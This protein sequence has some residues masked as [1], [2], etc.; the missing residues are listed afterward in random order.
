[1]CA[2]GYGYGLNV[3]ISFYVFIVSV[4][5]ERTSENI[6][7]MNSKMRT[8]RSNMDKM[9]IPNTSAH[10]LHGH[11]HLLLSSLL[12]L[13][14]LLRE[15]VHLYSYCALF[16]LLLFII[17][18]TGDFYLQLF[19]LQLLHL[20]SVCSRVCNAHRSLCLENS[21]FDFIFAIQ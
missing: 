8:P 14:L 21:H 13:L 11:R 1:M 5:M 20:R 4:R 12:L 2:H 7:I 6:I 18:W 16:F 15:H 9:L 19:I 3:M 10:N 17:E